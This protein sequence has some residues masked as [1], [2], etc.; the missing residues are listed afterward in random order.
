[1]GNNHPM[2]HKLG[3]WKLLF[4]FPEDHPGQSV[5]VRIFSARARCPVLSPWWQL[6]VGTYVKTTESAPPTGGIERLVR[7]C[8]GPHGG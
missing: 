5:P 1:M 4:D 2:K 7:E 6:R 8:N 3:V